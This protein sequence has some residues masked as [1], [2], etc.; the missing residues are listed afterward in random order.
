MP[1]A[2][3]LDTRVPT[4]ADPDAVYDAF[5]GWVG[6]QGL[7]LYPHQDEAVIE[8]LG[9]NHVILATPTGSGK[10]LVAI[11]AHVAA[12]AQDKVSFYTAPIKALVSEKFFALIEVFGADNVGMLT[13]DAAVNPDAPIICCTAEVLANIALREGRGADVGLVVMDEFHFYSEHDRGWAWQVPLLE[14]RR[15]PV[16]ADVGHPRRRLLLRR[17]PQAAHRPRHRRRRRRRTPGAAELP[18]V[19]GAARR[20]PRGARDDRAGPRLRRPLHPGGGRRARDQPA[21]VAARGQRRGTEGRQG[22]DRRADRRLPVR[23]G[24]RQDAVAAG[25]QRHRRPPRR[26]AAEVPPARRDARPGRAAPG[27]LRHRHPRRRHQRADPHR[28]VHRAGQ[29]RRHPAAGAADAGVPADRRPRRSRGLRHGRLRR[30]AGA[31]AT[32]SRTS[33]PRPSRPRG[34]R[35]GEEEVQGPAQEAARGHGGVDR[36]DLRQARRGRAGAARAAG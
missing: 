25:A 2:V 8:L 5:T 22:R 13:G 31:G 29:V 27:H 20:H 35:G 32:S 7:D 12:L 17:G 15:R 11:G 6:D 16:P 18:L 19:D 9:G 21:Q 34:S 4:G 28:A 3:R 36:A 30:R 26:H 14:L 24:L 10:S 23:R 1:D 33:R